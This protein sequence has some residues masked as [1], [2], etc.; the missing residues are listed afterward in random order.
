[1]LS[2]EYIVLKVVQRES[3]L[4]TQ[5]RTQR[6]VAHLWSHG[7]RANGDEFEA[8]RATTVR[9]LRSNSFIVEH[10]VLIRFQP[11]ELEALWAGSDLR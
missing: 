3:K 11:H 9:A 8:R 2:S 10:F 1:V 5:D 4:I 6:L 7:I